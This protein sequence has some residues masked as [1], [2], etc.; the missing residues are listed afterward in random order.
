M[1]TSPEY[2][3]PGAGDLGLRLKALPEFLWLQGRLQVLC[4][5]DFS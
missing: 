3:L 4:T 1:Q 5:T 2:L